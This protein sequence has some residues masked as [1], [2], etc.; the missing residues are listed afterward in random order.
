MC[1]LQRAQ[2]SLRIHEVCSEPIKS[3]EYSMT[4]KLLTEHYLEFL[5]LRGGSTGAY[6]STL[7]KM[8]HCWKSQITADIIYSFT[9]SRAGYGT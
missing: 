9:F 6:E 5:S 1:D 8:S 4:F 3:P 7:V 2:I